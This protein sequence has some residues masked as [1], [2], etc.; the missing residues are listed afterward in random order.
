[1][2]HVDWILNRSSGHLKE[3]LIEAEDPR[4]D[5]GSSMSVVRAGLTMVRA[6]R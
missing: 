4:S 1:M 6:M 3:R 5:G 2:L